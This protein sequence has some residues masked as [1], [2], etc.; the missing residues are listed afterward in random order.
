MDSE[1][2]PLEGICSEIHAA[3]ASSVPYLAAAAALAMPD[4][5]SSLEWDPDPHKITAQRRTQPESYK[6]WFR[7]YL[8][9]NYRNFTDDDCY[10]LRCGLLH[11]GKL[12]RPQDQYDKVAFTVQRGPVEQLYKGNVINGVDTGTLLV[13]DL[14]KFC[15]LAIDAAR[16]WHEKKKGDP[17]VK[18]NATTLVRLSPNG[19]PPFFAGVPALVGDTRAI[20]DFG[21]FVMVQIG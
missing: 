3:L 20:T 17:F 15:N 6:R 21:G 8:A 19:V 14:G 1:S 11:N 18:Q 9:K 16:E 5:C 2:F 10:R 4:I 13:L 7:D 12:G